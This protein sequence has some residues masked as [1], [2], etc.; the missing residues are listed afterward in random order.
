MNRPARADVIV[1]GGGVVGGAVALRL[2]S[3][4]RRVICLDSSTNQ[5]GASRASGAMLG[6]LAETTPDE[7]PADLDLRVAAAR[8][9]A[10]WSEE[11]AFT[12]RDAGTFVV[13]SARR[14]ADLAA[15]E[16]M[17][18]AARMHGLPCERVAATDA[19]GL[20]PLPEFMPACVL[21]LPAEGW[22]SAPD[23]MAALWCARQVT[24]HRTEVRTVEHR[25]D[26]VTGVRTAGG[27]TIACDEIVLCAGASTTSI[28]TQSKLET[29]LPRMVA[30][31]G[32][33]L[34]LRGDIHDLPPHV[35]RTPNRDFACGL[36]LVP[37]ASERMY[38]GA[39]NRASSVIE[40]LG[41][42]T[43]GEIAQ[44]LVG[45]SQELTSK[46][47]SWDVSR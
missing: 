10:T 3:G 4:G 1:V 39:T 44:L 16:A 19:P 13:A 15:I 43:G 29:L 26:R 17:E 45:G 47:S 38:L 23:L 28:L 11:L 34:L 21:H 32:V 5:H 42:A 6:V 35:L 30:A 24:Y 7:D 31:K 22:V 41:A 18:A 46:I 14:P 2:A 8:R 20:H 36:H 33:A 40:S 12:Q 37:R 9:H 27:E 25:A